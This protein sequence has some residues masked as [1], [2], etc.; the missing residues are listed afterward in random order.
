MNSK[1]EAIEWA[2]R[3]PAPHGDDQDAEIEIRQVFEVSDFPPEEFSP[4]LALREQQVREELRK[5]KKE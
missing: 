4:E 1:E 5:P 3:S 2:S